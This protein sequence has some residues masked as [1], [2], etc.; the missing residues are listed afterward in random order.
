MKLDIHTSAVNEKKKM[1]ER[2]NN[3]KAHKPNTQDQKLLELGQYV[4]QFTVLFIK[5]VHVCVLFSYFIL[6]FVEANSTTIKA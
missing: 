4:V 6:Y 1:E 3:L 5:V 2:L